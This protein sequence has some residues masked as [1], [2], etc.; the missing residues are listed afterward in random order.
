MWRW[1]KILFLILVGSIAVWLA[2]ELITFPSISRLRTE[3][4]TTTGH[5][6]VPRMNM[7]A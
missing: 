6:R 5:P 2:Y 3:N 4:P 7:K 1:T